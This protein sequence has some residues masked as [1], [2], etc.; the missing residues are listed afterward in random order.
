MSPVKQRAKAILDKIADIANPVVVEV[1]V[2]VG[3][4]SRELLAQRPDL[5]LIMVDA[6]GSNDSQDYLETNDFHANASKEQQDQWEKQARDMVKEFNGRTEIIKDLSVNASMQVEDGSVDLVF[7][8]ADHSYKGCK[9]DINSW[10]SKVKSNGW[11]SG[12]DYEN[13]QADFKFG[14]TEAVDEF[15]GKNKDQLQLGLNYTWFVRC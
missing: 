3:G 12:H 9:E 6:W 10:K 4:L 13:N 15:L 2:F 5:H 7:I 1:G 14:V 11:L 8:D